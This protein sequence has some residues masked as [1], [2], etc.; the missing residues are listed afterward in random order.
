MSAIQI[1]TSATQQVQNILNLVDAADISHTKGKQLAHSLQRQADACKGLPDEMHEGCGMLQTA[2]DTHSDRL[3]PA[4]TEKLTGKHKSMED[5]CVRV[6]E[7]LS[8][9]QTAA[10]R[11]NSNRVKRLVASCYYGRKDQV[12]GGWH[13]AIVKEGQHWLAMRRE[14]EELLNNATADALLGTRVHMPQPFIRE[15][16][17]CLQLGKMVLLHG[18]PGMGK[19]TILSYLQVQ[20]PGKCYTHSWP[21][22]PHPYHV[23]NL[24]DQCP[25]AAIHVLPVTSSWLQET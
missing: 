21:R 8:N 22:C 15:L 18:A 10:K 16:A 5:A 4:V 13:E 17:S 24:K 14:A 9:M 25:S 1:A 12:M 23:P 2:M 19:S 6:R 3:T 11:L 20:N 7:A